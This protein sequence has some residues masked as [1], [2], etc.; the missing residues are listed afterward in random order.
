MEDAGELRKKAERWRRLALWFNARDR[1]S[2]EALAAKLEQEADALS[3]GEPHPTDPDFA[4][5]ARP[6][7][8]PGHDPD[9]YPRL[10]P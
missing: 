10:P 8:V 9:R 6:A 3:G 2:I 7:I 1:L 5:R 4:T